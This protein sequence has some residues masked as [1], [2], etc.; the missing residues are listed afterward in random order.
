M[1][2]LRRVALLMIYEELFFL[3]FHNSSDPVTTQDKTFA[4]SGTHCAYH[5]HGVQPRATRATEC[6]ETT[7]SRHY[8]IDRSYEELRPTITIAQLLTAEASRAEDLPE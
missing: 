4:S 6:T 1:Y 2:H 7:Q 8:N 3:V 5:L